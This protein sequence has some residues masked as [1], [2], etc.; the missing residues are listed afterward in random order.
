SLIV[1]AQQLRM[2]VWFNRRTVDFGESMVDE[3]VH[4]EGQAEHSGDAE[5]DCHIEKLLQDQMSDTPAPPRA[6][7]G[8][9]PHLGEIFAHHMEGATSDRMRRLAMLGHAELLD[10]LV[11]RDV[12]LGQQNTVA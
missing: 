8:Q 10:V 6:V 1:G 3:E 4:L 12:L 11:Q 2:Y 7:D 9:S 5:F